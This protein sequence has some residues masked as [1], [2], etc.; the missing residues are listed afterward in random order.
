LDLVNPYFYQF[1]LTQ[2]ALCSSHLMQDLPLKRLL[3]EFQVS[4]DARLPVG[5]ELTSAHFV[6]G[7]SVDIV[8]WT[9][10]KGFQGE[11]WC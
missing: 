11:A 1:T 9:K 8:G 2:Q 4:P 3:S 10:W 6:P 7:Q 5:F